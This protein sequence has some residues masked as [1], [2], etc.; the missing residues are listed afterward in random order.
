[1]TRRARPSGS[2]VRRA[3][4]HP[5]TPSVAV[6]CAAAGVGGWEVLARPPILLAWVVLALAAGYSISGSV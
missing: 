4:S 6:A 1:M 2:V 5:L 3:L